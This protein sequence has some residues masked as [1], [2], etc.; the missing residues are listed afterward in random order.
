M[1]EPDFIL[2]ASDATIYG[3][4]GMGLLVLSL[5]CA[6]GDRRRRNRRHI[7]RVGIMPW[8]DLGALTGFAGLVLLAFAATGWLAGG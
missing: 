6:I 5:V 7:D 2:F 1:H 8:R 3:L 4:F